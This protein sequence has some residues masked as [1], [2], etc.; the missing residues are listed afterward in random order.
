VYTI[1]SVFLGINLLHLCRKLLQTKAFACKPADLQF[2]T[3]SPTSS[4]N[5]QEISNTSFA[6]KRPLSPESYH[7]DERPHK[8]PTDRYD[9][10]SQAAQVSHFHLPLTTGSRSWPPTPF[11]PVPQSNSATQPQIREPR[12]TPEC[13]PAVSR[14]TRRRS[15]ESDF[16]KNYGHLLEPPKL[17]PADSR[18][19]VADNRPRSA[20]ELSQTGPRRSS[21]PVISPVKER[22]R[23]LQR[24]DSRHS[25]SSSTP[26][27]SRPMAA[28]DET[29]DQYLPSRSQSPATLEHGRTLLSL[30]SILNP[31]TDRSSDS[32]CSAS[33]QVSATTQPAE[34]V[35]HRKNLR[36]P[37]IQDLLNPEPMHANN[38]HGDRSNQQQRWCYENKRQM[39]S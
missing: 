30:A 14:S 22:P 26:D 13:E 34:E 32:S 17:P 15:G 6:L 4:S 7:D 9:P 38:G 24:E 27:P 20:Q 11:R 36:L 19:F 2:K 29:N 12:K 37:S 5:P 28:I 31:P 25:V 33:A 8:I 16:R 18:Q 10:R 21:D 23:Y 35:P 1:L 3:L 39:P